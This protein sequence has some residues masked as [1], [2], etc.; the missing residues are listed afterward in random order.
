M[1][2]RLLSASKAELLVL[3]LAD[4]L[5][6]CCYLSRRGRA[7][8]ETV[9]LSESQVADVTLVRLL[10]RVDSEVTLEFVRVGAGIGAVGTLVRTLTYTDTRQRLIQHVSRW[11]GG[12]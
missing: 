1:L 9:A 12:L 4:H 3:L 10:S 6:G 2:H 11:F 8:L 5:Y 7:H